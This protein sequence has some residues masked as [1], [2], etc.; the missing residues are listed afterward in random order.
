MAG[1]EDA[2]LNE[3]RAERVLT[4]LLQG[5]PDPMSSPEAFQKVVNWSRELDDSIK[6]NLDADSIWAFVNLVYERFD[7]LRRQENAIKGGKVAAENRTPKVSD[8]AIADKYHSLVRASK[9]PHNIAALIA[10]ALN[11]TP[12][13]VRNRLDKLGLREKRKRG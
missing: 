7:Q 6:T 3:G 2:D 11:T 12:T 10:Q 13:T 5:Q 8:K 4:L 9:E 1:V